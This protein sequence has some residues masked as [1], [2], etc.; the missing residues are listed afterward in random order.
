MYLAKDIK[1]YMV[2]RGSANRIVPDCNENERYALTVGRRQIA[3]MATMQEAL[4][5]ARPLVTLW[6]THDRVPHVKIID[7][8]TGECTILIH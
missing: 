1:P 7:R 3:V 5:S 6:K 4:E 8:V 2:R